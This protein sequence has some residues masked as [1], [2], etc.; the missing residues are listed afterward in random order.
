MDSEN[1]L[2]VIAVSHSCYYSGGKWV[3]LPILVGQV[4]RTAVEGD[5]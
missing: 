3:N 5:V 1:D 4:C 2:V